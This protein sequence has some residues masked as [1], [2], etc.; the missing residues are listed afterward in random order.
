MGSQDLI[1]SNNLRKLNFENLID[2]K[3]FIHYEHN[4]RVSI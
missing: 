2:V 3:M 4:I 1:Y